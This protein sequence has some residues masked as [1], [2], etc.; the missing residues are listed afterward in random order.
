MAVTDASPARAALVIA[1]YNAAATIERALRSATNQTL[2]FAE[3]VVVDDGSKDDT[4]ARAASFGSSVRVLRQSNRGPGAARNAGVRI[5]TAEVVTFLD[6][7]DELAPASHE[8][9]STALAT[10]PRAVAAS[11]A[12]IRTDGVRAS[13]IPRAGG[14]LA[15]KTVGIVPD[16]FEA[17]RSNHLVCVGC[18]AIRRAD[19][20]AVG[21]F[22]EDIRFG[23][24][25]FLW[26][27]LAGRGDWVF[28]DKP[29]LT[30]H[31]SVATSSTI[32]TKEDAKPA[33]FLLDETQM[34]T[35]LPRHLW[36]SYR[37]FRRDLLLRQAR[38]ALVQGAAN[39]AKEL[40]HRIEKAPLSLGWIVTAACV[41]SPR[42]SVRVAQ[43]AKRLRDAY[44]T[45]REYAVRR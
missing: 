24:D 37:R 41:A 45:A 8:T 13:R 32:K 2:A 12:H 20:D 28:V 25:L 3:V 15:A 23:E 39:K 27:L 16:F 10:H 31:H 26:S 1:A 19:Y 40:V 34:A 9:L 18:V 36:A 11:S 21:G 4:A 14:V 5:T 38:A 43:A 17:F 30:Y 22:R 33:D 44:R 7:D 6:A 35:A 42:G 29:L